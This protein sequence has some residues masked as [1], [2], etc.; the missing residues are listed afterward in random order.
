[1]SDFGFYVVS[2]TASFLLDSSTHHDGARQPFTTPVAHESI[3][4]TNI[5]GKNRRGV[6][7]TGG[8]ISVMKCESVFVPYGKQGTMPSGGRM[9]L[10][11]RIEK[12]PFAIAGRR[13]LPVAEPG[14]PWY[15]AIR[16]VPAQSVPIP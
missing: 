2:A 12:T 3:E 16:R 5:S 9:P 14:Q 8:T 11:M 1:M 15:P 10:E 4:V 7:Q 6:K 13:A